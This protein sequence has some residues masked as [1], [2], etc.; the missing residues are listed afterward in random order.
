M[1]MRLL[2]F[3]AV[4]A[5]AGCLQK[6]DRP[7]GDGPI[8]RPDARVDGDPGDDDDDD[9]GVLDVDDNCP[10]DGNAD[11]LDHDADTRGDVCDPCPHMGQPVDDDDADGDGVGNGC[12]PAPAT[13][14]D[15]RLYFEGFQGPVDVGAW[16]QSPAGGWTVTGGVLRQ[17]NDS[18]EGA[19]VQL[20]FGADDVDVVMA[21]RGTSKPTGGGGFPHAIFV[22]TGI[23]DD[24]QHTCAAS[25]PDSGL[26]ELRY[27]GDW[28]GGAGGL[29]LTAPWTVGSTLGLN[30]IRF[31][32]AGDDALCIAAG[33][34]FAEVSSV[35][36]APIGGHAGAL[37]LGAD[38]VAIEID[39]VFAV[40]PGAL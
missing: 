2:A 15:A 13:L 19:F 36:I 28:V 38:F 30:Y 31:R 26:P 6:P 5:T 20:P 34:A 24:Q 22:M 16:S 35:G 10:L 29:V 40:R 18:V 4:I 25:A 37:H 8:D 33:T 21:V 3:I 1:T 12:D 14:G 27:D 9:D 32:V 11:Q 39:F 23:A 7:S 17:G